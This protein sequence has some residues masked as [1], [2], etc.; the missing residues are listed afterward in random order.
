MMGVLVNEMMSF[1]RKLEEPEDYQIKV[2]KPDPESITCFFS[3]MEFREK[4][5]RG[6]FRNVG[7][8]KKNWEGNKIGL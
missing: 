2:N 1:S 6:T 8:K 4:S 3:Y 7:R 5:K